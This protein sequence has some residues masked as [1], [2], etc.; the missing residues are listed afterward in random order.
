MRAVAQAVAAHAEVARRLGV[1]RL[2]IVA[3]AAVREAPNGADLC[4]RVAAVTGLPVEVLGGDE[5]ARLAFSGATCAL[6]SGTAVG[7]ADVGGASTELV[8]GAPGG[9]PVWW[10]SLPIGSGRLT[11]AC[12]PSDPP[13]EAEL[14]AARGAVAASFAAVHPPAPRAAFAVG[15]GATSV[16]RLVGP[17]L[18]ADALG[19]ALGRLVRVPAGEAAR[20]LDL[21][22]ERARLLP[23]AI[24]LL[25]HAARAF[26]AP[27]QIA[28]GGLREG[29]LMEEFRHGQ[30]R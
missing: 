3:T 9:T 14:D 15:G 10:T 30:G 26:G 28:A 20:R 21:H 23:A 18:S 7:V 24:L 11:E 1:G 27:L 19:A 6:P 29:V 17:E 13:T 5:E 25:E 8:C 4:A 22:P 2:R 16:R 12:L